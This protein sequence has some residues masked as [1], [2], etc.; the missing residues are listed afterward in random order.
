MQSDARVVVIGG[1]VI[2][3][4]VA[5]R[6]AQRDAQVTLLERDEPGARCAE[7]VFDE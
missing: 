1:G 2:G 6:L 5:W 3:C 4:G 7:D